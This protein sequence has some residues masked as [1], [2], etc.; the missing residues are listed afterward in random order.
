MKKKIS[1]D[2]YDFEYFDKLI[3]IKKTEEQIEKYKEKVTKYKNN[4]KYK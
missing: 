4:P 3:E 1:I 2:K